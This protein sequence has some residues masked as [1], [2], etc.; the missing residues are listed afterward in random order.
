M[1]EGWR[2]GPCIS[3]QSYEG[4]LDTEIIGAMRVLICQIVVIEGR[5]CKCDEVESPMQSNLLRD[6]VETSVGESREI[7]MPIS[8]SW[9]GQ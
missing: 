3:R 9:R 4:S 8:R 6:R 1:V 7:T 5:F 2:G